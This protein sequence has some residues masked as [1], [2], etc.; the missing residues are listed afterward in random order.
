MSKAVGT[1]LKAWRKQGRYSQLQ[2]SLELGV[3]ARHISFMETGRSIPSR[4]MLVKIGEFLELPKQE[5]NRALHSS[6]YASVYTELSFDDVAL[7]PVVD[8]IEQMITNH[9]PYPAIVLNQTWDIVRANKSVKSLMSEIGFS[10]QSNLV[11]AL[12]QDSQEKSKIINWDESIRAVLTRL[13][14]EISRSCK[15]ARLENLEKRLSLRLSKNDEVYCFHDSQAF[16]S[17]QFRAYKRE[18]SFFSIISQL[19]TIQDVTLSEYKI[20]LMFPS[21]EMTK[22]FYDKEIEKLFG[23]DKNDSQK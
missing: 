10:G 7:R 2:L 3:S 15:S 23:S 6:G 5:I 12:I 18:L 16:L 21:N 13:R 17:I 22:I 8:A 20:E 14:H 19:S 4:Q 11:E 9:M 1:I